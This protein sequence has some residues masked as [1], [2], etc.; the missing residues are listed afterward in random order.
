MTTTVI[1]TVREDGADFH[2]V[3]AHVAIAGN[4]SPEQ[5]RV[6][7]EAAMREAGKNLPGAARSQPSPV[8]T[9][10]LHDDITP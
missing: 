3:T 4:G 6:A 7:M 2:G 10:V 1:V 8:R 5:F 9:L